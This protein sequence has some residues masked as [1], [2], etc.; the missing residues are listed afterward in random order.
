MLLFVC[1]AAFNRV[2]SRKSQRARLLSFSRGPPSFH[3][4]WEAGGGDGNIALK[5]A[6]ITAV[7]SRAEPSSITGKLRR[8]SFI[9]FNLAAVPRAV[10]GYNKDPPF[11]PPSLPLPSCPNMAGLAI[12]SPTR[13]R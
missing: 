13:S 9:D 10:Y 8:G 12:L 6:Q 5:K 2:F 4:A 3:F 11:N 1:I 7:T